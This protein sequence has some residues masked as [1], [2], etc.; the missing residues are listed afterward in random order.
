MPHRDAAPVGAPCWIELFSSDTDKA[1]AFYGSLFGWTFENAG[2]DYGGYINASKD[3][4][5][6]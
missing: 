6:G 2:P 3:G 4:D 1:E 5:R